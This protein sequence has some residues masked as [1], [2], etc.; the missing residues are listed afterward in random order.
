M[1]VTTVTDLPPVAS[2]SRADERRLWNENWHLLCHRSEVAQPS[3][4]LRLEV[5]GEEVVAFHDGEQVIVFDNLCPHRGARVFDGACGRRRWV[6][7]YH[8]WSFLKGRFFVPQRTTFRGEDPTTAELNRYDTAWV[9]DFLFVA[10]APRHPV[11]QQLAGVYDILVAISAGIA[12]RRDLNAYPYACDWKI[13]VEN[14]LDQYHVALVHQDTLNR[15]RLEPAVDE[16]FGQNNVSRAA[17]GDEKTLKKLRSLGRLFDITYQPDGYV[18]IHLFPFTFLTT[19]FGYSYSLQQFYPA[20]SD[21]AT[22]FTSRFYAARLAPK[23]PP[24]TMDAFF[25]SS[26]ALNHDVFKEDAE[27]CARLPASSW[28][29]VPERFVCDGEDKIVVFR[30]LIRDALSPAAG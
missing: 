16:H 30:A 8:G 7:P 10:R 5:F 28:S 24:D 20:A 2:W 17:L 29:S 22:A 23:L 27:I 26:I 21:G 1:R 3:D 12:G 13:A 19:T 11:E 4:Y 15:L 6:C 9:G 18:A 14:A 25:A